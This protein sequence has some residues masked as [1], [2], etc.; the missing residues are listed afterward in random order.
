[1]DNARFHKSQHSQR[2]IEEAGTSLGERIFN[3][4]AIDHGSTHAQTCKEN[5]H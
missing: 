4:A 5:G 1:M 3:K 2:L